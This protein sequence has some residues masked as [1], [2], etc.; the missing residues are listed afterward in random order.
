MSTPTAAPVWAP[1]KIEIAAS[2]PVDGMGEKHPAGSYVQIT[3]QSDIWQHR[4]R[5]SRGMAEG[6]VAELLAALRATPCDAEAFLL[7]MVTAAMNG[8][9][10]TPED[11]AKL[12]KLADWADAPPPPTWNGTLDKGETA[13]AVAAAR[14]R[15]ESRS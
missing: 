15:L 6:L 14:K 12:R 2:G 5:I 7:R 11:V 9:G 1:D 13:R 8:E 10:V 3:M 4:F